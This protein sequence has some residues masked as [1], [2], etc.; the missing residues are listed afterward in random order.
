MRNIL[1][2]MMTKTRAKSGPVHM[3]MATKTTKTP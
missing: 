2:M 3:P 1:D